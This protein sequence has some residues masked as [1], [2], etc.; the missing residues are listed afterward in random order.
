MTENKKE[1]NNSI[2]D[3]HLF[4]ETYGCQMNVADS[5]V[6]AS[7]MEMAGY[8]MTDNIEDA[9]AIL[10]NTCSIRDNAEQKI[11]SRLQFLA[12]LR[13]K[14]RKIIVGV[15]GCMAERVK[16]T[17]INDH[18]VDLVAGP[19]S[20]LDLPNLFASVEAGEKA[21]NVE[22]STTE[23]YR[24][25]IPSRIGGNRI[26]GFISI[27]RGCNNFCS[28]CIV[29]YTRGRERS[30]EAQS[31]LNELADLQ[32]KGF[33][34]VTL[35]GQNVNSYNYIDAD[36]NVTN[37]ASLLAM[38]AEA[39]PEM[40]V[41]F[42]T[43]HPKDMSDEIIATIAKYPN[44]CNHIHL[45]V[46]S[47]S[48]SVLKNMNR[49]YTREWYLDRIA[50]IRSAIP[51]CGISTDMFTGFYDESEED[52][53][54]TLD[55]MREVGFDASFMFKYSERPGTMASKHMP[56]NIAEDVKI[57]RLNRMIAL[58]NELSL[59]SNR[60]DIGKTFDVLVEGI[61]KRSK[62]QFVGRTQQNK[63]CVFPR[64]NYRVGDIVNVRV[65]EVSSAT[66]ICELV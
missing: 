9:D 27:M 44:V 20:Y 1:I 40:R 15:I 60:K 56:D 16:D 58:Q 64:G 54:L 62:E 10:L 59:E 35:L 2:N 19:D 39:A 37:F 42:T 29:P 30:R 41:R 66:L 18:G 55:L 32:A 45:P 13:R 25:V 46:Q 14:G 51:D 57:D 23:T 53:Q 22:L 61:S 8:A 65:L 12:S 21:I 38:V 17:L 24:N 36:G 52:F 50:A 11:V 31:I 28:Y 4:I 6:V 3:R 5:E 7:I 26:S 48:N 34:E 33:K 43:S 63:T 47:G 49:R